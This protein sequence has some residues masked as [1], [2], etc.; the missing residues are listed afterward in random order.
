[1][2]ASVR[3]IAESAGSADAAELLTNVRGVFASNSLP[4]GFYTARVT[5][6]GFLPSIE[7]HIRVSA[8][9]TTLVRV[10]LESLFSSLD[11]LRRQP[12][13]STDSDDW[14]WVLR[15]AGSM[16]PVLQWG[17]QQKVRGVLEDASAG[18]R[19]L[20]ELATGGGQP[21][22]L[23]DLGGAPGT[24]FAYDQRL[25]GVGRL[26]LASRMSYDEGLAA[27]LAAV[28][29]PAGSFAAGPHSSLVLQESRLGSNGEA[30]RGLRLEHGGVLGLGDRTT[31]RYSGEYV[32]VG[33]NS[34]ASAVRPQV[35]MTVRL[36]GGWK[37]TALVASGTE[38]TATESSGSPETVSGSLRAAVNELN[39][40]PVVLVRDGHAVLAGGW[41][42]ELAAQK[43]VGRGGTL[44]LAAM[45]DDDSH[46]AVFGRGA[47]NQLQFLQ[48]VSSGGFAYDGGT[49]RSWGARV[50]WQQKLSN[51]VEVAA[52]YAYAGALAPMGSP[53]TELRDGLDMKYFN[54]LGGDVSARLPKTRTH[55]RAE[56]KWVGGP[57]VSRLDP[58]GDS[59]FQ[60]DPY[61]SLQVRQPLPKFGPGR[62]EA[63]A[64]CQN[65]FAQGYVTMASHD[66]NVILVPALRSF[67]G[68]VSLQF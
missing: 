57:A 42:E 17:S 14:K 19:A 28:W 26:L 60:T 59:L 67:R 6:A 51:N 18:P 9:L 65:L 25:G 46:T 31:V 54:S 4:P 55:L 5:L 47:V 43:R 27:G 44:Q 58:F 56:Y 38:Q 16:R 48:D 30:F 68:G 3:L 13:P 29:L 12:V 32:V 35:A 34:T 24:A 15:S 39:A 21:G 2:G 49:S 52:I 8:N 1:M 63:S 61:F 36:R 7:Q 22:L 33:L 62:W 37:A 20:L 50:A 66:G 53:Q 10:E 41:H 64:E 11:T 45:H 40:F 23:S